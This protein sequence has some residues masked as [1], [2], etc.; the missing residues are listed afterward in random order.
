MAEFPLP[1]PF[2]SSL[3]FSLAHIYAPAHTLPDT[4]V[5]ITLCTVACWSTYLWLMYEIYALLP[6]A[7]IYMLYSGMYE[8]VAKKVND[9]RTPLPR[10][11][12]VSKK[13]AERVLRGTWFNLIARLISGRNERNLPERGEQPFPII[14]LISRISKLLDR[15]GSSSSSRSF[16]HET[17]FL[18]T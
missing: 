3:S 11:R 2:L 6:C 7:N 4:C 10:A 13:H 9:T 16:F 14:F 5:Y 17:R 12:P 1:F 15:S 8:V 18:T